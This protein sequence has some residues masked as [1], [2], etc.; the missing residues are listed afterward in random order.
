MHAPTPADRPNSRSPDPIDPFG[1]RAIA[2]LRPDVG[3]DQAAG[4]P[5][6]ADHCPRHSKNHVK[7]YG[8]DG[9]QASVS[10]GNLGTPG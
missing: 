2:R 5:N 6:P 8:G 4:P 7:M 3:D 1:H 10:S 9:D